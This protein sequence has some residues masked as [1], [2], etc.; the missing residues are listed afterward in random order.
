MKGSA[1]PTGWLLDTH[2]LLWM[3]YGDKRLSQKARKHIDGPRPLF[4]STVSFWEIALKRAGSGFDFEIEDNWD[5][6]LPDALKEAEVLRLDLEA[7][8]C[9]KMEEL[10]L[11]HRDPF[12]RMLIAQAQRRK[13]GILSKDKILDAYRIPRIW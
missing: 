11:H 4:Y 3:L 13:M 1:K 9:R 10:P 7:S 5:I 8:D 6:L 2:A 12:D